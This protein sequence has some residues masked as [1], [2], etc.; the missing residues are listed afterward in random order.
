MQRSQTLSVAW[1][2]ER[3]LS[4]ASLSLQKMTALHVHS[5]K[6]EGRV[7]CP[8]SSTFHVLYRTWISKSWLVEGRRK[9]VGKDEGSAS[10]SH[11]A[12]RLPGPRPG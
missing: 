3:R 8:Q 9:G 2:R 5:L 4:P 7:S 1:P 10:F 11:A 12:P 6:Q